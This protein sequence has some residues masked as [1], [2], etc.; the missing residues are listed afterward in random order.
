MLKRFIT[1]LVLMLALP[2]GWAS[3]SDEYRLQPGDELLISVW[4]EEELNRQLVVLPDG[5]ISYPLVG[6]VMAAGQSAEVLENLLAE[7]LE[8]YITEPQVSVS[9]TAVSGNVAFVFGQVNNPGP[10]LMSRDLSVVQALALAG[11]FT[12]FASTGRIKIIREQGTE[13]TLLPVDYTAI[14][15]SGDLEYNHTLRAGDVIIVP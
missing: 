5:R 1:G 2:A 6:H 8:E 9:V 14:E 12:P 15:R 7:H 4:K 10:I 13:K 11:G 3:A